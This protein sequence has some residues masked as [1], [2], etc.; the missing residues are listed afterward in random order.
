MD[1]ML[2]TIQSRKRGSSADFA[3][4]Q[5]FTVDEGQTVRAEILLEESNWTPYA[6]DDEKRLIYFVQCPRE[7]DFSTSAFVYSSQFEAAEKL[8]SLSYESLIA[9]KSKAKA[10]EKLILIYSM[11]RCGSTLMSQILNQVDGVYSLSE[12]D[13]FTMLQYLRKE[14]GSRDEELR[15]LLEA[16]TLFLYPQNQQFPFFALKFRSNV[17]SLADLFQKA[18]PDA[19]NLFMYRNGVSWAKS[20]YRF[21]RRLDYP[22]HEPY[23]YAESLD[24]FV[25]LTGGEPAYLEAYV[26]EKPETF[27]F[28]DLLAPA[29]T[30]YLDRY[31]K[32]RERGVKFYNLRYEDLNESRESSLKALL[33]TCGLPASALE[34]MMPAFE[35]DSQEGTDIARDIRTE[36]FTKEMVEGFL[37]MLSRHPEY[38]DADYR[39][40]V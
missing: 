33:D 28:T 9:L 14:D 29:W 6:L 21:L 16:S 38:Q 1:A 10:P 30:S 13:I 26:K 15:Q 24:L 2:Y 39:L 35:K 12:P 25:G 19:I 11:G 27:Q 4:P 18:F 34:K 31:M 37:K 8:L 32:N 23:P 7:I 36:E 22:V 20:V 17:I 5:H 40:G 3:I